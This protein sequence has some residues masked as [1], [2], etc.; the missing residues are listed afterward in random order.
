MGAIAPGFVLFGVAAGFGI[1]G[2]QQGIVG[3]Q[4][5]RQNH[6]RQWTDHPIG[7]DGLVADQVDLGSIQDIDDLVGFDQ[8]SRLP[9]DDA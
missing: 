1:A 8:I 2:Q 9:G 5:E 6:F 7:D 4:C 3:E